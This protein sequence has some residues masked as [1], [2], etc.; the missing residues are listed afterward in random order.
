MLSQNSIGITKSQNFSLSKLVPREAAPVVVEH[1][2]PA[3]GGSVRAELG[4]AAGGVVEAL[5]PALG[6]THDQ[7]LGLRR[8]AGLGTR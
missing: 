3:L 2:V 4:V 6:V 7:S 8:G 1:T 5:D